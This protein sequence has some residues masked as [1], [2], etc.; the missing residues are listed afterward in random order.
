MEVNM[1]YIYICIIHVTYVL[2]IC[3]YNRCM[4]QIIVLTVIQGEKI[5]ESLNNQLD[6]GKNMC[7]CS[8]KLEE[9]MKR[10]G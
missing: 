6:I 1:L 5:Q 8:E 2:C 4:W 7:N 10:Y 3:K 9:Y